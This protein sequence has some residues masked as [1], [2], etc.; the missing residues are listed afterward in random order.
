MASPSPSLVL[1]GDPLPP[2]VVG[3]SFEA[4]EAVSEP[5]AVRIVF[6]TEDRDFRV[7]ACLR[8][9]LALVVTEDSRPPRVF[10]G[11]VDEARFVRVVAGV[12]HFEVRIVPALAALGHREGCR[13][14]QGLS[15]VDV[16]KK[17]LAE[18]GIERT[19]WRTRASYEPR[20]FVVQYRET[21]L[22]FL[23]RLLEENGIFY[24][25]EHGPEG[26]TLIFADDAAAFWSGEGTE[27]VAFGLGPG[28]E[29][30]APLPRFARTRALRTSFVHLRDYDFERPN[31]PPEAQIPAKEAWP[32]P[33]FE[34]PGGFDDG[35]AA[36][37]LAAARV[38]SLRADADIVKGA[39]R[40]SGLCPGFPFSVEG[41]AED[42]LD[43]E[44]VVTHLVTRG[45][46][47]QFGGGGNV[48]VENDFH[49]LPRGAP[50]AP[51][52]RA[53]KSRIRGVQ[54]AVVTGPS[55]QEQAIHVD[56]HGRVKVRFYWDRENQED[57]TSSCWVRVCQPL[58]SGSMILPRVGWEVAVAFL[59]GDP[60]RPVVL[61]RLYNGENKPPYSL[62]GSRATGSLRSM[63]SPGAAGRNEISMAD[64][65]GSQGVGVRG[66]KDLNVVVGH[67]KIE[68]VGAKDESHVQVNVS[69]S[70]GADSKAEVGGNQS[71][72]VGAVLSHKVG[73]SQSITVG[74]NDTTN[75]TANLVEKVGGD[76]SYSVG[77]NRIT[78]SNGIETSVS[79]DI[80][81]VVGAAQITTSVGSIGDN[82]VGSLDESVGAVKAEL[83]LGSAG[84]KIGGSKSQTYAAGELHL[85]KGGLSQKVGGSVT[86]LVGGLHYQK[87]GGGY[88]VKSPMIT[89]LGAI[90]D[91]K[92]GGS[93]LKL[94]GGPIVIKGSDITVRSALVV[95]MSASMKLG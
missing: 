26:H 18:A 49:A 22:S 62:P 71:V 84:E 35:D 55:A 63:S 44:F 66:Q 17:V 77:G 90:G 1:S 83:T 70:I 46:Q 67:D 12:A 24:Y 68:N 9:R 5:Y 57:D 34:Y 94:G 19:E 4:I 39:S 15:I 58:T 73:G 14:F 74:G 95:K 65:A 69:T 33:H 8:H 54:T 52:R 37:R 78:I 42:C 47:A 7:E 50:F 87:V 43:G 2:D 11:V 93:N 72:D 64:S 38:R 20:E 60:D 82:V 10:D 51:P 92:G 6:T 61:G 59:D 32:M 16:V 21:H 53:K 30:K 48:Q 23:S 40:A 3:A 36:S 80:S 45:T 91:F 25:F 88:V 75:A 29:H 79:G 27:P 76:R 81:R 86:S 41:A 56:K 85:S 28:L 89:L 31:T 13:I